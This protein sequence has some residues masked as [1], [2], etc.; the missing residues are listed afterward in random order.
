MTLAPLAIRTENDSTLLDV[1]KAHGSRP[2]YEHARRM[3]SK[4]VHAS[5]LAGDYRLAQ[6]ATEHAD[7]RWKTPEGKTLLASLCGRVQSDSYQSLQRGLMAQFID[8][9]DEER[10]ELTQV[11]QCG[12]S[13]SG[14]S[15]EIGLRKSGSLRKSGFAQ[16]RVCGNTR[17]RV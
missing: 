6:V 8:A 1:I 17:A 7:Y 16:I 5:F 11:L 14:T 12:I 4:R 3:L 2:L 10:P 15:A 13:A 9:R